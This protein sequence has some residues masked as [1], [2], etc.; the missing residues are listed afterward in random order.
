M[1]LQQPVQFPLSVSAKAKL[2][3]DYKAHNGLAKNATMESVSR[4]LGIYNEAQAYG[5]MADL[6]NQRIQPGNDLILQ[7]RRDIK[8]E[9]AR[10][11]RQTSKREKLRETPVSFIIHLEIETTYKRDYYE[12]GEKKKYSRG[13]VVVRNF[14]T[15]PDIGIRSS[16]PAIIEEYN[17]EDQYKIH[18]V[19]NSRI[20]IMNT[21]SISS[22]IKPK[23]QQRMKRSFILRNDWLKYAGGIAHTAYEN[24]E[25][26]CVYAQLV[27][28]LLNPPSGNPSKFINKRRTSEMALFAFFQEKINELHLNDEYPD[29]AIDSGV[30]S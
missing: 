2:R 29:F 11:K 14:T 22:N 17:N 8:N 12:T 6:Y 24:S 15:S 21:T 18:L 5:A 28:Y 19:L 3:S 4:N 25:D 26:K 16:I 9:K 10:N 23:Q 20:E 1:R 13:D 7:E 30:S 27:E